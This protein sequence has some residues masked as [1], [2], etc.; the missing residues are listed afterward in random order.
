MSRGKSSSDLRHSI[1]LDKE[2]INKKS[3]HLNPRFGARP[4]QKEETESMRETLNL[5]FAGMEKIK[6]KI[7]SKD[8]N[9]G[10]AD[11]G[12]KTRRNKSQFGGGQQSKQEDN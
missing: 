9:L 7:Q 1:Y 11:M 6:K 8:F 10:G 2:H 5:N 12:S 3:D 4:S